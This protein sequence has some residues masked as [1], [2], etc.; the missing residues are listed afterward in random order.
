MVAAVGRCS[1]IQ[2]STATDPRLFSL[3]RSTGR[4]LWSRVHFQPCQG[5]LAKVKQGWFSFQCALAFLSLT[6]SYVTDHR[7]AWSYVSWWP[8]NLCRLVERSETHS[9]LIKCNHQAKKCGC[10]CFNFSNRSSH[11][12]QHHY[13]NTSENW[14]KVRHADNHNPPSSISHCPRL[15]IQIRGEPLGD[16]LCKSTLQ[17]NNI[18]PR[19][20]SAVWMEMLANQE[21][22]P[23]RAARHLNEVYCL[24]GLLWMTWHS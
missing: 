16:T 8:V 21:I 19:N 18:N 9:D 7:L 10:C 6:G 5:H 13:Q 23:R 2:R 17:K 22:G 15:T 20:T 11:N 24:A 3:W 4:N 14:M 12:C 1:S